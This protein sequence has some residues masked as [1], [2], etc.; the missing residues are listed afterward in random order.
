M[1]KHFI[2]ILS[3]L[4][5]FCGFI[6]V[7]AQAIENS[8][9]EY[10]IVKNEAKKT[11]VISE[12]FTVIVPDGKSLS[13]INESAKKKLTADLITSNIIVE[14]KESDWTYQFVATDEQGEFF[15]SEDNASKRRLKA[16][17]EYK[18]KEFDVNSYPFTYK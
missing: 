5:L 6:K 11:V 8:S 15:S 10:L 18:K 3:V 13:A 16:I 7:N 17:A 1:K 9:I 2:Q 14:G 12:V 4:F